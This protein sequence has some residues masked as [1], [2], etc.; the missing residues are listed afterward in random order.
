MIARYIDQIIMLLVGVWVTCI[1]FGVVPPP[2]DRAE[3]KEKYVP[4]LKALGPL[5]MTMALMMAALE[6]FR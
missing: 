4:L 5:L 6:F 1:G 3:F 2:T